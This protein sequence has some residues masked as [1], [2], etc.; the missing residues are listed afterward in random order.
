MRIQVL[1]PHEFQSFSHLTFPVM[2]RLL[3][4]ADGAPVI[5]V[6]AWSDDQPVGLAL[7]VMA[8][9]RL[10]ELA[11]FQVL[12]F[13][14][15][16]LLMSSLLARWEAEAVAEGSHDAI[17]FFTARPGD[18]PV[19]R[20]FMSRGWSKPTVRNMICR[21]TIEVAFATKWFTRTTIPSGCRA[22]DWVSL[23]EVQRATL[24]DGRTEQWYPASL[25]PFHHE[26]NCDSATS[27]ALLEANEG[28]ER[29]AG[30][31]ITHKLDDVALRWTSSFVRPDLQRT[32]YIVPL[33]LEVAKR[34]RDRTSLSDFIFTVPVE[35]PRM[36]HFTARRMGPDL[37]EWSFGCFTTRRL[38]AAG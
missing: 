33:W 2:R 14:M 27:V 13:F 7:G 15:T 34:Q 9:E 24:A 29:L 11:S 22:V 28:V 12:P 16:D 6:G 1:S 23:T 32:G 26:K 8:N 31:V 37:K 30:W 19:A 21:A 18:D 20:F 38:A 3:D 25:D 5:P 10:C 36:M 17:H 35:Q 4:P